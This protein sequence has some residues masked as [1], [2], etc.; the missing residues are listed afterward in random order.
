[1][2]YPDLKK[3]KHLINF[4]NDKTIDDFKLIVDNVLNQQFNDFKNKHK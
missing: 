4:Q 1:M 3:I 2:N